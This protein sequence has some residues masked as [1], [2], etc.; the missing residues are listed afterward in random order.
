MNGSAGLLDALGGITV[1]DGSY[2]ASDRGPR[3][4]FAPG[5]KLAAGNRQARRQHEHRMQFLD[6]IAEGT[7]PALARQIQVKAL[8]GDLDCMKI[9]LDYTLGK[10]AQAVALTD[11][12]GGPLG[13][14][15]NQ[16]TAI[17]LDAL[18]GDPA[19]RIEVARRLMELDD[20]GDA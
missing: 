17:V 2:R 11:S 16:V 6:A 7:I 9:L 1:G 13:V 5:N 15:F 8:Q 19:K 10:P 18:A 3:G 12:D 20:A 14:N 4:Q